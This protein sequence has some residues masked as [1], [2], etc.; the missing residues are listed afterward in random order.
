MFTDMYYLH[1]V[2]WC[3][4]FNIKQEAVVFGLACLDLFRDLHWL[5][6]YICS[7][8]SV[9][10]PSG[11]A[12]HGQVI[13]ALQIRVWFLRRGLFWSIPPILQIVQ[14]WRYL[15]LQSFVHVHNNNLDPGF[16]RSPVI[17]IDICAA[18]PKEKWEVT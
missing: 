5:G 15:E 2:H 4:M 11:S 12:V 9:I 3:T 13:S 18:S 10:R 1:H 17:R 16:G 8:A 6:T 14:P 7:R